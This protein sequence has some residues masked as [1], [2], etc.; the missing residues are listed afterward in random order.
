MKTVFYRQ[1]FGKKY[2]KSN[3][4]KILP[5]GVEMFHADGRTDMTELLLTFRSFAKAPKI[6]TYPM[7]LK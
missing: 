5:V 4:V 1:I 7:L 6:Y 3:F 2:S